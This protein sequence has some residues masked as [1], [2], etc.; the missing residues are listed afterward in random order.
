MR[1]FIAAVTIATAALGSGA[2]M[3]QI[4]TTTPDVLPP[5]IAAPNESLSLSEQEALGLETALLQDDFAL[6]QQNQSAFVFGQ[7]GILAGQILN[8]ITGVGGQ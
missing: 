3:A 5:T 6:Q 8:S 1:A 4:I 2:A 7:E